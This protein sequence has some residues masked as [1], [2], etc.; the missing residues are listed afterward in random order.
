M[1][2]CCSAFEG[3]IISFDVVPLLFCQKRCF[4]LMHHSV[5]LQSW[6]HASA[7]LSNSSSSISASAFFISAKCG[8]TNVF[9]SQKD[10]YVAHA[11]SICC[12]LIHQLGD[13]C[14]NISLH[15]P[16]PLAFPP[17]SVAFCRNAE[18]TARNLWQMAVLSNVKN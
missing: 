9:F 1:V 7:L 5:N 4:L 17:T 15:L 16:P 3:G 8:G 12:T 10:I 14:R 13:K 11:A 2:A 6:I 18:K